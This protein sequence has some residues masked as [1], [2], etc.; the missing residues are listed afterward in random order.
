MKNENSLNIEI[1]NTTHRQYAVSKGVS[2]FG[3][4]NC[5]E[6]ICQLC[7]QFAGGGCE[8]NEENDIDCVLHPGCIIEKKETRFTFILV[9]RLNSL[10]LLNLNLPV[11]F[12]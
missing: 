10:Y 2:N 8:V 6:V 1:E 3:E 9:F 11:P 12:Y 7:K 4:E 5:E